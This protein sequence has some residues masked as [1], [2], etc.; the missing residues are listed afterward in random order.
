MLITEPKKKSRRRFL[1]GGLGV[2]GALVVGWG[3]MPPRQRL[4]A[5][6]PLPTENGEVALNGWIKIGKD[7][8]VTVAMPRAE[9]GQGVHTALPMLV[10]EEMDVPLTSVRIVQSPIDKIYGNVAMLPD[11][12]PFHPDDNGMVKRS[13][14]WL[15]AKMARELG[16]IVTGGSSS[17]KDA[18]R[19]MREAGATA[20]A[21]LVGVAAK[22]WRVAP[23]ECQTADGAVTHA[24]GKRAGYGELAAQAAGTVPGEIKLKDPKDFKLIGTP[25]L[26]RDSAA[27]VNGSAGFGIDARPEGLVYAALKM[28]PTVGGSVQKFDVATVQGMP[29]VLHVVDFSAKSDKA[30]VAVVAKTFWQAKQAAAA[31]PITWNPGPNAGLS[32]EGIFKELAAKLDDESGFAYYKKGDLDAGKGAAQTIKAEYRAPFLAHATMEPI[33]CTALVKDGKVTLWLPT[34]ALGVVP[35]AASKVAGVKPEDVTVHVTYLGGGFG[36]RL[37]MDMVTQ[38]VAIAMQ[39]GG[40]PVQLIWTR[41]ED[42][43]HDMYR[44]IALA[45]FSA[46]LDAAG[47]VLAYDN[48]SA[49]GSITTQVLT[50]TFGI[51]GGGPDKTTAEGE[52]DM[53]YEFPNQRIAHVIVPT[54]VPLGYWRSVGHSHNAFFKESFIDEIAHAANK[55]PVEY[56]RSLLANHPRFLAALNAA[57]E[58][59][60]QPQEGHALG[61]A[62]HR[63]FGS[64]VAQVAEVS[65]ESNDIKVHKVTCAVDCGIAV[66]PNIIEQQIQSAIVF[67]LSAALYG[68]IVFKDGKVEQQNF[69]SYQVVRMNQAPEVEVIVIKSA[70]PPEGIGEPGLPPIAPAVANAVFKLTGKRLRSLPLRLA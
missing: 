24:S 50:R 44:P 48:K 65:I 58:K 19:P 26:R 18:W 25:Q 39:T 47:N 40:A 66:N 55:D 31:L 54:P 13:A 46:A 57:V 7:G 27:K 53:P 28:S 30:G 12:L 51:P 6:Q 2:A 41:E 70:E 61:V 17:V 62:L 29:G 20:R 64:I 45:R 1:L 69:D 35:M 67:G 5:N 14:Q 42:M 21:M 63:S 59:A 60:G 22:Q 3:V 11:G 8:T 36:R 33:N 68:E 15:T 32:S 52:Y 9:M 16:L 10:A 37:E 23:G 43:T 49:G 38:A 56:R 4:N 34:Q